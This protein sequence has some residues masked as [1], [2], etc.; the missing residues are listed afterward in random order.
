MACC[1]FRLDSVS[2]Y[3]RSGYRVADAAK[4]RSLMSQLLLK[5]DI[6]ANSA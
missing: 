2:A 6:S 1:E 5:S 4:A 3:R